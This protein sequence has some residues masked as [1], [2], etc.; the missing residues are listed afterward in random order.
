MCYQKFDVAQQAAICPHLP[1]DEFLAQPVPFSMTV[2]LPSP[3]DDHE[4]DRL[5]ANDEIK[6]TVKI[7]FG[8]ERELEHRPSERHFYDMSVWQAW[9][10][11]AAQHGLNDD[12]ATRTTIMFEC[13]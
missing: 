8:C 10:L 2:T 1:L 4:L 11:F 7:Y 9:K 3:R 5:H 6:R 13:E 12:A